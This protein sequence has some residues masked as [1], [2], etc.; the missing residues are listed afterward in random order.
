MMVDEEKDPRLYRESNHCHPVRSKSLRWLE[1]P[2]LNLITTI[3]DFYNTSSKMEVLIILMTIS[4]LKYN[5]LHKQWNKSWG[6]LECLEHGAASSSICVYMTTRTDTFVCLFVCLLSIPQPEETAIIL[7]IYNSQCMWSCTRFP[8][9]MP[10]NNS[11]S[12]TRLW[13]R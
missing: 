8:R 5:H 10:L 3:F 2:Q 6:L 11:V 7:I 12:V 4:M 13:N 9:F 1:L